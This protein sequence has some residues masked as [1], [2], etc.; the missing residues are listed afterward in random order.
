MSRFSNMETCLHTCTQEEQCKAGIMGDTKFPQIRRTIRIAITDSVL[1]DRWYIL[2]AS[3][4]HSFWHF[5]RIVKCV[6]CSVGRRTCSHTLVL[7]AH[8]FRRH[9][10]EHWW[11]TKGVSAQ[12]Q[13]LSWSVGAAPTA[14]FFCLFPSKNYRVLVIK[15]FLSF[16][17][18]PTTPTISGI[19]LGGRV[20]VS[21]HSPACEW[22][23]DTVSEHKCEWKASMTASES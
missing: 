16:P 19:A 23:S 5:L 22:A 14:L 2:A 18:C 17:S 11:L 20:Y 8:I 4:S 10:I 9:E 7:T 6:A 21:A 12:E 15:C 3:D 13:W 1:L